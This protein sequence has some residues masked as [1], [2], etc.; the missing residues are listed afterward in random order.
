MSG[1]TLRHAAAV[2]LF[3]GL[4]GLAAPAAADDANL[5]L[6]CALLG[7]DLSEP[8][9]ILAYR[10]CLAA[11]Q[12]PAAPA[13]LVDAQGCLPGL[14]H[15]RAT[16]DDI[17]CVAPQ[18]AA[19]MKLEA[20]AALNRSQPDSDRCQ[21]G[22]V[23]REAVSSDHICVPPEQR[24]LAADESAGALNRFSYMAATKQNL[25]GY[26]DPAKIARDL[27]QSEAPQVRSAN[28]GDCVLEFPSSR[29]LVE[30]NL[31]PR[32]QFGFAPKGPHALAINGLGEKAVYD[33]NSGSDGLPT[34]RLDVLLADTALTI[35]VDRA[36]MPSVLW[37]AS[38]AGTILLAIAAR[39][40]KQP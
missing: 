21:Q 39:E 13:P 2:G 12:A 37:G 24:K 35:Q 18:R 6:K 15:R 22:F 23:W 38:Q 5:R 9:E 11:N 40:A 26:L 25:C 14:N 33:D 31:V 34:Q 16:R 1:I 10:R 19:D 29:A 27:G 30:I 8:A 36:K 32:A 17:V 3:A 20:L 28:A 4:A 7:G